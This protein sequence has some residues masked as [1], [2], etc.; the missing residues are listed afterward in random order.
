MSEAQIF[1]PL[2]WAS[3]LDHETYPVLGRPLDAEEAFYYAMEAV[4]QAAWFYLFPFKPGDRVMLTRPPSA[5]APTKNHSRGG[6]IVRQARRRLPYKALSWVV[7]WDGNKRTE[8]CG[9]VDLMPDDPAV[10]ATIAAKAA[11]RRTPPGIARA[12][13]AVAQTIT[14]HGTANTEAIARAAID[15]YR[16]RG[17]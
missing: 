10:R 14:E 11:E 9:H 6:T 17:A 4:Q 3:D 5:F 7:L 12:I 16:K 1:P 2:N 8:F 15:A 13:Q